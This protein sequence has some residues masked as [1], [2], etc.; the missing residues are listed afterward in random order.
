MQAGQNF[1]QRC[2]DKLGFKQL[3]GP[4]P[5]WV[6]WLYCF[7]GLTFIVFLLQVLSG[8]YLAMF[9]QATPADAWTSIE[10]IEKNVRM[11]GFCRSLHRWGALIMVLF[12]IIHVL[13][14]LYHGAYRSPR[15]LNWISG[16]ALLLLTLAFAATGY[17]LPWDFRS[18]WTVKTIGNW[19]ENLPLFADALKWLLFSDAPDGVV[20]VGRW[21]SIH[22]IVLPALTGVFLVGHFLM[23]RRL[24]VA[25]PM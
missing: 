4:V 3:F 9:F 14:I 1:Y 20:P 24:G 21:F 25:K 6:N 11:G 17:L 19:L 8:I 2:A 22:A 13:R 12:L 5:K 7:G 18:Y 16:V 10:F 15:G 23:V